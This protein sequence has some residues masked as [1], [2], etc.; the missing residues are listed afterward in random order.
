MNRDNTLSLIRS[1]LKIFGAI[2]M[3]AGLASAGQVDQITAGLLDIIG[4]SMT[5]GGLF[6]SLW[7]HTPDELPVAT[8]APTPLTLKNLDPSG[9]PGDVAAVMA[10]HAVAP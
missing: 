1:G 2:A 9:L 6:W 8:R 3:T 5:L 4:T 10:E 7:H